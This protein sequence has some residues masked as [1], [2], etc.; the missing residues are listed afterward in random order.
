MNYILAKKI[1]DKKRS[2]YLYI[3]QTL[4]TPRLNVNEFTKFSLFY[5]LCGKNIILPQKN[6]LKPAQLYYEDEYYEIDLQAPGSY[7][8]QELG[9]YTPIF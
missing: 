7:F 8:S 4:V 5:L 6:I 9:I 3:K 1:G 2:L